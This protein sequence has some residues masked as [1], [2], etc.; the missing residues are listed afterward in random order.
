MCNALIVVYEVFYVAKVCSNPL[1]TSCSYTGSGPL[2]YS[3]GLFH[4]THICQNRDNLYTFLVT[5]LARSLSTPQFV[6]ISL[7]HPVSAPLCIDPGCSLRYRPP[8][9]RARALS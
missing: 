8:F 7:S 6:G 2:C 1:S 3:Q 9:H 5:L 4:T